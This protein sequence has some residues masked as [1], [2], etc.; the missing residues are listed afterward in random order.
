[1]NRF[2][3]WASVV[4]LSSGMFACG[5]GGGGGDFSVVGA[6]GNI[7]ITANI[8]EVETNVTGATPDP[9]APYCATITIRVTDN[10]GKFLGGTADVA[11]E[12]GTASGLL[13]TL[14]ADDTN[15]DG[16]P[17]AYSSLD[18]THS[19][20]ATL[21]FCATSKPGKTVVRVIQIDQTTGKSETAKTT[22]TVG[23]GDGGG[24]GE[25]GK[26]SSLVFSGAFTD[27]VVRGIYSFGT[28]Q[29]TPLLNGTYS[30][31]ITVLA[32]NRNGNPVP[33]GSRVNFWVVDSP[34]TGFPETV[35]SFKVAGSNGDP[36]EGGFDFSAPGGLFL[37]LG[38][39][40]G[41]RLVLDDL[42]QTG[43]RV[44]DTI[45]NNSMLTIDPSGLAFASSTDEGPTIPYVVGQARYATILGTAFTDSL[46]IANTWLTYPATRIGQTAVLVACAEDNTVC[47]TLNTCNDSGT[48]CGPVYLGV[49]SSVGNGT[50]TLSATE[51]PPNTDS[52]VQVCTRDAGNVPAAT[53]VDYTAIYSGSS[54]MVTIDGSGSKTGS[55]VTGADGC[56]TI[57][58]EAAGQIGGSQPIPV[59]FTSTILNATA[60]LTIKSPGAGTLLCSFSSCELNSSCDVN[61]RLIDDFGNEVPSTFVNTAVSVTDF[62]STCNTPGSEQV[63]VFPT[64]SITPASQATDANGEAAF[65]L[66]TTG[67]PRDSVSATFTAIGGSSC[68]VNVVSQEGFNCPN[69]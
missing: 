54:T 24:N 29:D 41:D 58:I 48:D 59:N 5:G 22:F 16:S 7:R 52:S 25:D 50:I 18:V 28:D 66:T 64:G 47:S 34:L 60:S 37:T 55:F 49:S 1:M 51:L 9:T 35:G 40:P 68:Q 17:K 15:D 12:S 38:V 65:V 33:P 43:I 4:L 14:L 19:G 2:L 45:T 27:A 56:K 30:R 21:Y 6:I 39:I 3:R 44:V 13:Y 61:V 62:D 63:N 10:D 57:A 26:I 32:T 11:I 8:S 69:L 36:Q 42:A 67:G 20:V 53:V 46:G 31:L 23:G